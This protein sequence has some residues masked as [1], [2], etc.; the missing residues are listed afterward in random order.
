MKGSSYDELHVAFEVMTS[1]VMKSDK[2]QYFTP[3]NVVDMYFI[4]DIKSDQLICD[5]ACGSGG[6][7]HAVLR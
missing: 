6:F 4:F 2:G 1:K 3:F 7:L 5:P